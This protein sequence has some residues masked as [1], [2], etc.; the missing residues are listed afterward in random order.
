MDK[1]VCGTTYWLVGGV[2]H[3]QAVGKGEQ[4]KNEDC[5]YVLK[6][7]MTMKNMMKSLVTVKLKHETD[8][9]ARADS[10]TAE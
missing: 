9:Y 6:W 3:M 10:F 4:E 2:I 8:F 5:Y 7:S 1:G